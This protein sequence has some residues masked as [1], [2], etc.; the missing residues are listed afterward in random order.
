VP[1]WIKFI[2]A[3]LLL[4]VC[5]GAARALWLVL[6]AGYGADT[7]WIPLLAGAAVR[8]KK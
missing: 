6:R 7:V 3:V 2:I 5:A 8:S 4:P 1:K